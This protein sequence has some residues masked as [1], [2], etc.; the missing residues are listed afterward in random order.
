MKKKLIHEANEMKSIEILL[1]ESMKVISKIR[2]IFFKLT[3]LD[4]L[5]L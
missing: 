3:S 2:K 1:K 4:T 5:S